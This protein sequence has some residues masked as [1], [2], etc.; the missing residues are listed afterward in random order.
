MMATCAYM[1]ISLLLTTASFFIV[2]GRVNLEQIGMSGNLG[3]I[4]ALQVAGVT[5]PL[6]P[7]A[8][9]LLTIVAAFTR[10]ARE[11]QAWL[12]LTQL[13]PTLPLVFAAMTN[14]APKLEYM[15]VPSLSQHFL[16]QRLL[17]DEAIEPVE[18]AM[19]VGAALAL[20]IVLVF[21]ASRLYRREKLLG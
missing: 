12:S 10:S 14:L 5:A 2:L 3:P 18:L 19:S 21:I 7:A 8:A 4:T 20:G 1:G 9:A 16:I 13:V 11:A 17:R 6:I 15:A